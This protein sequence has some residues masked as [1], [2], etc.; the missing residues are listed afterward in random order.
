MELTL[1]TLLRDL[2][3]SLSLRLVTGEAGLE[4]VIT[5]PDLN[6]PGLI[7]SGFHDYFPS[8][9]L[10]VLGKTEVTFWK[11]LSKATRRERLDQFILKLKPKGIILSHGVT[12][13]RDIVAACEKADVDSDDDVDQ[14]DFG[15]FQRCLSGL[16][17]PA[18]QGCEGE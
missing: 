4:R 9:R 15:V 14:G 11:T 18:V 17:H 10:Q 1:K 16:N 13:P 2:S 7:L 8:E 3:G 6:R 5:V 12:P